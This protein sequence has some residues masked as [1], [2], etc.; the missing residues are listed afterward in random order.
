S[1]VNDIAFSTP[2][3]HPFSSTSEISSVQRSNRSSRRVEQDRRRVG[4]SQ[5]RQAIAIEVRHHQG[6]TGPGGVAVSGLEAAIAVAQQDTHPGTIYCGEIRNA[7]T[8]EVSYCYGVGMRADG[9]LVSGL[10]GAVALAQQHLH[11][12]RIEEGPPLGHGEVEMA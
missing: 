10:E 4:Q 8:V 7:V 1:T 12:A 2:I 6:T 5:I 3:F 9:V 11:T